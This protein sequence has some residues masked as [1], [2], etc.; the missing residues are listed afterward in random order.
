MHKLL[1]V[2][3]IALLAAAPAQAKTHSRAALKWMDAAGA[4]LPAGAKM[5]VVSGD[6][7]KAGAF[8]IRAKFPAGYAVPAHHH[9]TAERVAVLSGRLGYGMSDKLNKAKMKALTAGQHVVMKA[10][11]NHWVFAQRPTEIQVSGKG[12]FQIVYVDPKD[13]P[14]K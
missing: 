5:A 3:V 2:S 12:P 7:G 11:M 4:G 9:P 8:V 6:P 14:R 1:L 13:D 10:G